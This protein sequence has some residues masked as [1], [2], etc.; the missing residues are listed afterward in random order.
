[1]ISGTPREITRKPSTG[2]LSSVPPTWDWRALNYFGNPNANALPLLDEAIQL[3]PSF[4]EAYL[5]RARV[6]IRDNDLQGA[7]TDLGKADELLP[8]SPLVYYYLAQARL[9]EGDDYELALG[10]AEQALE[11]DVTYLPTYLLLGQVHA[12]M[13]N[14]D[15]AVEIPEPVHRVRA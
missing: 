9:K 5:E 2:R 1:M 13:E 14:Y 4:G 7:I 3:D 11:R 6:K 15:E 8:G 12:A 10:I